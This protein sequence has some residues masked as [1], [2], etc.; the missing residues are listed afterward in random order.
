MP[1]KSPLQLLADECV[2]KATTDFLLSLGYNV[3]TAQE[4]GLSGADDDIVIDKAV[5]LLATFSSQGTWTSA[6]SS[7][8]PQQSIWALWC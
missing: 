2:Y 1:E 6:T 5:T 7:Y 3:V 8:T 4:L